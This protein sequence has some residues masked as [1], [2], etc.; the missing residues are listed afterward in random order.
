MEFCGHFGLFLPLH[1][2]PEISNKTIRTVG[3]HIEQILAMHRY[4]NHSLNHAHAQTNIHKH[5]LMHI[6]FNTND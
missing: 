6:V 4:Q 2:A 1:D 3:R 5:L